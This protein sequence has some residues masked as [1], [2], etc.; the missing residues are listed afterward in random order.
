MR[1]QN[2]KATE[3]LDVVPGR[4][5]ERCSRDFGLDVAFVATFQIPVGRQGGR[6][7]PAPRP[8]VT[9]P[10]RPLNLVTIPICTTAS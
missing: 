3:P 4:R 6:E 9:E 1:Q 2:T 7:K 8:Y 10:F 5:T